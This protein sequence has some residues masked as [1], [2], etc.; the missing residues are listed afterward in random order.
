MLIQE[1]IEKFLEWKATHTKI[2][3]IRYKSYLINMLNW[4]TKNNIEYVKDFD[5]SHYAKYKIYLDKAYSPNTVSFNIIIL[6]NF[7]NF[8]SRRE[9]IQIHSAD[10]KMPK[11][12]YNLRAVLSYPEYLK[13]EKY[14]DEGHFAHIRNR[15]LIRIMW[16]TGVRVSELCDL[17]IDDLGD[18]LSCSA[19]IITKKNNQYRWIFWSEETNNILRNYLSYRL[20]MNRRQELF[21]SFNRKNT[22]GRI[23]TRSVER[24]VAYTC[25]QVGIKKNITP[26]SFRHGKAHYMLSMGANVKEVQVILGHSERNPVA[27]FLYLRLD[28]TEVTKIAKKYL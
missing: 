27:S 23:T 11:Q 6:K 5:I 24:I 17:N 4:A 2:A 26:H 13:L 16:E 7:F 25:R 9:V 20:L 22:R 8:C 14:Y 3:H 21:I 10:I 18:G 19:Q 1:A 28:A 15:L 12:N